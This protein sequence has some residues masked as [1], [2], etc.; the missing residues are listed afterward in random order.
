MDESIL[1][2]ILFGSVIVVGFIVILF[3]L[4]IIILIISFGLVIVLYVIGYIFK[5][6]IS[7]IPQSNPSSSSNTQNDQY[8]CDNMTQNCTGYG[9]NYND[10]FQNN[11]I[12]DINSLKTYLGNNGFDATRLYISDYNSIPNNYNIIDVVP[13]NYIDAC[14]DICN[15]QISSKCDTV[16]D[17][18]KGKIALNNCSIE[19]KV[20]PDT[21][22]FCMCKK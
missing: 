6:N 15:T 20:I 11:N 4:N 1:A 2:L 19:S 3:K 16:H 13:S 7:I 14:K 10:Y 17:V 22:S 9:N 18:K 12:T 21:K 8:L 5:L